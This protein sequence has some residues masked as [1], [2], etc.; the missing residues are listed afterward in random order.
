MKRSLIALGLL[1]ALPFAASASDLSYNYVE[2][3]YSRINGLGTKVD[4]A[5]INGSVAL[6]SRFHLFG[7]YE[8]L[9]FSERVVDT[10]LGNMLVPESDIDT[11]RLGVGY[12]HSLSQSTDLVARIGHARTDYDFSSRDF[13]S[14]F[15]EVGVRSQLAPNVEGYLFAGYDKTEG[16]GESGD[17]YGR[18]GGQYNFNKS[19]GLVADVRFGDGA[20]QYFFGPR[21]SF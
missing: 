13:K 16:T 14:Y 3:G 2:G 5:A 19:W 9:E 12:N 6:G 10:S 18:L 15:T 11:W 1:A 17:Y 4:G 7:G 20:E 21:F 8:A